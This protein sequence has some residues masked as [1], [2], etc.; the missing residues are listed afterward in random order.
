MSSYTDYICFM[1]KYR[2]ELKAA[3]ENEQSKRQALLSSSMEELESILSQQQAQT[4]KLKTMEEKRIKLQAE[5]F[6][7][8][9]TAREVVDSMNNGEEKEYFKAV[10]SEISLLAEDI[11]EQNR[12]SLELANTN[13]KLLD[14][15]LQ[16]SGFDEQ[17]NIYG[18]DNG[19]RN[20]YAT[21]KTFEGKA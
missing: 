16:K 17:K 10:V 20:K 9:A 19:R 6:P 4:M 5:L 11:K 13:L 15:I 12:L 7:E 14:T 8:K 18:P 3:L 1:E 2:D 21:G